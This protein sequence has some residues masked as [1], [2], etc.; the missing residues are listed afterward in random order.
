VKSLLVSVAVA[1][2]AVTFAPAAHAHMVLG[3]YEVITPRD[4][5]HVWIWQVS[6]DSLCL[7]INAVPR[8]GGGAVPWDA[9]AQLVDGRYTMAVDVFAGLI[10]PGYA[11]TTH[12][13]YSWDAV[14][15]EGSVD[16]SYAQGCWGAPGGTDT[17]P[18]RLSR[19]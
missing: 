11:V 19:Y 15:L 10:C 18:F 7:H 8:P 12:D 9:S 4:P 5:V 17:Y 13:T 16:S 14:T 2:A 1:I 6:C 3:N